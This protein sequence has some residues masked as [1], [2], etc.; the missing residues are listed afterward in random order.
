MYQRARAPRVRNCANSSSASFTRKE[1]HLPWAPGHG[2]CGISASA[3]C[4]ELRKPHLR[5]HPSSGGNT[6][7]PGYASWWACVNDARQAEGATDSG[8]LRIFIIYLQ[9]VYDG[10]N[11]NRDPA[12]DEKASV[13]GNVFL[14]TR[15][16]AIWR[17][18]VLAIIAIIWHCACSVQLYRP[19]VEI[20][21]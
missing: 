12:I 19:Y 8:S 4:K 2:V 15:S 7:R 14:V 3:T 10:N 16:H 11:D 18:P 20:M 9:S 13:F 21:E 6:D 17:P 1:L 5:D